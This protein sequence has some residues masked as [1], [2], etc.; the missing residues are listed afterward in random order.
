MVRFICLSFSWHGLADGQYRRSLQQLHQNTVTV[1]SVEILL[2][3]FLNRHVREVVE[4][5]ER[6]DTLNQLRL[7]FGGVRSDVDVA[8]LCGYIGRP[9]HLKTIGLSN[10]PINHS[11]HSA[12][13]RSCGSIPHVD[14]RS[15]FLDAQDLAE[16]GNAARRTTKLDIFNCW[17]NNYLQNQRHLLVNMFNGNTLIEEVDLQTTELGLQ[18]YIQIAKRLQKA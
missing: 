1:V 10:S 7:Q 6:R 13:L 8:G 15:L 14:L 3:G 11:Q 12:L 16:L 2:D 5:L 9:N 4:A 18:G 17:I